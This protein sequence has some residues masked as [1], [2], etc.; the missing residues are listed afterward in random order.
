MEGAT[1][2]G[3]ARRDGEGIGDG[4]RC[5]DGSRE[6]QL[7]RQGASLGKGITLKHRRLPKFH[8]KNLESNT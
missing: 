8:R 1:K 7:E 3:W 6:E 2:R 5:G 4:G